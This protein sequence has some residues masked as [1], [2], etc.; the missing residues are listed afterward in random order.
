[1]THFVEIKEEAGMVFSADEYAD[2][3]GYIVMDATTDA[4][5]DFID[6]VEARNHGREGKQ[7]EMGCLESATQMMRSGEF[8]RA[9]DTFNAAGNYFWGE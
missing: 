3:W 8:P 1:M 6:A 9:A 5:L 7:F 4:A 2:F